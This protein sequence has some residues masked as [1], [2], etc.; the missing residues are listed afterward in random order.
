MTC[1]TAYAGFLPAGQLNDNKV[2]L[3]FGASPNRRI[4]YSTQFNDVASVSIIGA[5]PQSYIYIFSH[6]IISKK[7]TFLA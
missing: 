6:F 4:M 3:F 7:H 1:S 2:R 5:R